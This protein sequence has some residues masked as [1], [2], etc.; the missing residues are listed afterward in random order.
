MAEMPGASRFRHAETRVV[1]RKREEAGAGVW[2]LARGGRVG[3]EFERRL[4]AGQLDGHR[5]AE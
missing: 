4:A 3:V 1:E 5:L 2:T